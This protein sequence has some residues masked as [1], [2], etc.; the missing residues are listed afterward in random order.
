M[1][2]TKLERGGIKQSLTTLGC[3]AVL[4]CLTFA[5]SAQQVAVEKYKLDNGLIV[6]LHEDH[7]LPVAT[8]NL[9]YRVG[10]QDEPPG[11]SGFAHLFEHLMFMGTKRV[12]GS[13]FDVLMETGG[14]ANNASTD[15]HRTNYFSWGP[16]S[17]L[18]TL[19]WLDADRL[20]DMGLNMNQEKLDKQ[21]E[22]VRNELRQTVENQ[23][24]G[25]ASEAVW[26]LLF[27]PSHPYYNGIIGTHADLEA[28]NVTNVKDFFANFY[29]PSNASLVVAGDFSSA[30][31]KP[32][33]AEQFGTIAAGQRVS[34]KYESPVTPPVLT[35]ERR[36]TVIDKVQ[37]PK[38]QFNYLSP[39]A[40]APG[41]APMRM[42]SAILGVG[43]A[44]RLEKRL[45][46]KE[47]L[48]NEVS[49][50]QS[51]YPLAG[52]FTIDV[53]ARPEAD[54]ARIEAI[55]DE[56][57]ALLAKDGPTPAELQAIQ[58]QIEAEALSSLQSLRSKADK[59][60]EYEYYYGD[61]NSF[62]RDL[63]RFR[64]AT[65]AQIAEHLTLVCKPGAKDRGR[66]IIRVLPETPQRATTA[67]DVRPGPASPQP[68]AMPVPTEFTLTSGTR[69]IWY[70][71]P[72]LP[73]VTLSLVN[74]Q[75]GWIDASGK[76][77]LGSLAA[78]MYSEGIAGPQGV[79]GAAFAEQLSALG[80]EFSV[81]CDDDYA[82]ASLSSLG[83]TFPEA[84]KLFAS[85][86]QTPRN[87]TTD[88]DRVR[89]LHLNELAQELDD[90][91]AAAARVGRALLLGGA[92]PW[93]SSDSGLPSHVE[94]LT[95]EDIKAAQAVM[96]VPKDSILII[97]GDITESAAKAALEGALGGWV[98]T[99]QVTPF[100]AAPAAAAGTM[101]VAIVNRPGA[102]QTFIRFYAPG[103][104]FQSDQR[105]SLSLLNTIL[106]GSFTSR[107][108]QN[109]RETNGYTYG[110]RSG[111]DSGISQ[112][113][114]TAG[115]AVEAAVTGA[116]I[117]EFLKEFARLQAADISASE[118]GKARETARND[119]VARL[120]SLSGLIGGVTPY[121]VG[122]VPVATANAELEAIQRATD[123]TLNKIAPT[124]V[125]LKEGVLVLV[126]D[127]DLILEQLKLPALAPFKLAEPKEF[128]ALGN[129]VK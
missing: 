36:L 82:T 107:L 42:A 11:R 65:A 25:K 123:A 109:L 129:L 22:V 128:D 16:S 110:A 78:A 113:L 117:G 7:S 66:V 114:F 111:F 94:K 2:L 89:G 118:A 4:M 35:S 41:D 63:D 99:S 112:G 38:V 19:L 84:L 52:I 32:Y 50:S 72:S 51:G 17:L 21:R 102:V 122:G 34:R 15:L 96:F 125:R 39:T 120:E 5:A 13:D 108:N 20:E 93:G 31:I 45:V 24:Y 80:A 71:R 91:A 6:I 79:T 33:I 97:A 67:R 103:V 76:Q 26:K 58:A 62:Q 81:D 44:S 30:E 23:P 127:K 68:F 48:A 53:L 59:L 124:S 86:L 56:E 1:S 43:K 14:G 10:A 119:T 40:Y 9:W 70:P 37:L 69:V 88:W 75:V 49:A 3:G 73:L 115:A 54:L 55:I 77:G 46:V 104:T 90:P 57:V 60:N 28:A 121:L 126:G 98:V 29:V 105:T 12:P 61:P 47:G 83:R 116:A 106:G 74:K 100:S 64:T 85:A 95:L 8:V 18:K 101:R 92:T 87:D 27:E